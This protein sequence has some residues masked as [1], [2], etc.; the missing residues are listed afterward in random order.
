MNEKKNLDLVKFRAQDE[1]N[2]HW[3]VG[4][5]NKDRDIK[6]RWYIMHNHYDSIIVKPETIG[7][8]TNLDIGKDIEVYEDDIVRIH[9]YDQRWKH[10][11]PDFDWRVFRVVRNQHV[12]AFENKAIYMPC[13]NYDTSTGMP[14]EISLIGNMFDNPEVLNR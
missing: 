13:S 4:Y 7:Q 1:Y 8:L 14:Y 9:N 6:D 11:E 10:G 2:D 3:V 5:P 12:W